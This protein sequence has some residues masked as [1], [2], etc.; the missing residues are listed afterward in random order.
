M[1]VGRV[2]RTVPRRVHGLGEVVIVVIDDGS[3]DDT[4]QVARLAGARV[5]RHAVPQGVGAVFHRALDLLI[6]EAADILVFI[7][8]D[9]QFNA[10]DIPKVIGPIL[11]GQADFVSASRYHEK[12]PPQ[13][14]V[15]AKRFGNW[16]MSR[17]VSWLIGQ[18]ICDAACG[19]RAYSA[20]VVMNM[21][22][23]GRFTYTQEAILDIA[24]KRFRIM[25]VPI[26]VR[27]TRRHGQSKVAGNLFKYGLSAL[28]IIGR[29][30]RDYM[31]LRFFGLLAGLQL[32]IAT[33]LTGFF[34][35]HYLE[36]GKFTPYLSVGLLA[37]F[38]YM[39]G[40]LTCLTGLLADMSARTRMSIEKLL[41]CERQRRH[42]SRRMQLIEPAKDPAGELLEHESSDLAGRQQVLED[43]RLRG[44]GTRRQA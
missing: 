3:T 16:G 13:R 10:A 29:V 28:A 38:L 7:D 22:L 40:A 11:E 12:S 39:M 30:Y 37:G 33:C 34:V 15:F 26:R 23:T 24:F 43:L 44:F 17:L 21:N 42:E 20:E 4:A 14:Q 8:G 36:K 9:G 25:E 5:V 32:T 2:V 31:P 1:T 18:R 35:W 6:E 19:F 27:G 41:Y